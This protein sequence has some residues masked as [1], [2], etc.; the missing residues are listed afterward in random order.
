MT[1]RDDT[2]SPRTPQPE[3]PAVDKSTTMLVIL[4]ASV[5][6]LLAILVV[7]MLFMHMDQTTYRREHE[8]TRPV[9]VETTEPPKQIE[10][11]PDTATKTADEVVAP[12]PVAPHSNDNDTLLRRTE[13]REALEQSKPLYQKGD[14]VAL[15]R[16][17]GLVYRGIFL[18]VHDGLALIV[19]GETRERV[20]VSRLDHDSRIRC[21]EAYRE[22]MVERRLQATGRATP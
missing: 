7:S 18:G 11:I 17:D 6:V 8:P 2:S 1:D 15:R 16:A 9:V 20:A 12:P 5:I 19:D 4:L 3:K 10:T 14:R 21:D 13:L 22:R